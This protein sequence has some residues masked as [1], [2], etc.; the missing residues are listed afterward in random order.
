[1]RLRG[2]A[3][4]FLVCLL[5]VGLAAFA[6]W[7]EGASR[8]IAQE[9]VKPI[10]E[11]KGDQSERRR[12][13]AERT[14]RLELLDFRIELAKERIRELDAFQ[15]KFEYEDDPTEAGKQPLDEKEAEVRKERRYEKTIRAKHR[16]EQSFQR[17]EQLFVERL[18]AHNEVEE[19]ECADVK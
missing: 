15:S 2:F 4:F 14:A 7:T 8:A 13:I 5:G 18:T 17:L 6:T 16:L 3:G 1:M 9:R 19:A 11:A 10:R 12:Q